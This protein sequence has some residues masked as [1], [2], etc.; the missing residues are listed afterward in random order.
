MFVD[1]TY[2]RDFMANVHKLRQDNEYTDVTLQSGDV[3]MQCHRVVLAVGSEYFKALFRCGLQESRSDPVQ[4]TMEPHILANIIDYMYTGEI[5]L[6]DDNVES[7]VEACDVLQLDALKARC[8][9]FMLTQVDVTNCVRFWRLSE[10][11]QLHKVLRKAKGLVL[12]EFKTVAFSDQF[13][14]LSC[15]ELI[16]VIKEDDI[17][18]DDEDVVVECV[19][20][21]V[22][23]DVKNR[24][25][26]FETVLERTRL[27]YCSSKYLWHMKNTCQLLTPKCVEYVN[28][29]LSFQ[30]DPAHQHEVSTG[31]TQPRTHFHV[32]RRLVVAGG[33]TC[34]EEDTHVENNVCQFYNDDT[35]C[36]ETL[37]EMPPSVGMLYSVCYLGRSLLLTGG[38]KGDEL[39]QCWLCDLATRKWEAM[40]P[41]STARWYHRSVSLGDSVYVVG[42]KGVGDK[43]LA[44]VEC[45]NVKRR[46]WSAMPDLPRAV[47]GAMVVTYGNKVFVFGGRDE[48]GVDLCCTQVLDTTRGQWSTRSDSPEACVVGAAVTLNDVIYVVGGFRRTCLKY[49]PATDTWTRLSQPREVHGNA[50]AVVWRG[51]VLVAG[52]GDS[53]LRFS[54]IEHYHPLTDTWSRWKSELNMKLACH[55]MLNVDLYDV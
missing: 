49:I 3:Q 1:E 42:G 23:H 35:S 29:A 55:D 14:E 33:L 27:P 44:S 45:F 31:R 9:H 6:T 46:Q 18:V 12:A 52:G 38:T 2:R 19:L 30:A 47:Y 53:K 13:K 24:T 17:R 25:S 32:K 22:S 37:T 34:T 28:E 15:S 20:D 48:Q 39:N 10:V 5:E 40:P 43:V 4:L 26:S 41:L 54:V 51:C 21:W 50:P 36:W 8:E 11:Y 16:D 7:L